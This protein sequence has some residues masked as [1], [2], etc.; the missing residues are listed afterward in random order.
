MTKRI[1]LVMNGKG[2]VG[3]SFFA[4]NFVQY[5]LDHQIESYSID[6]DNEN[7]TLK[8]FHPR[9]E[10]VN[11]EEPQEIDLIFS[12]LE[13][14]ELVTVDCRAASTDLFL[15]Y[16]SEIHVFDVLRELDTALTV[17]IPIN[18]EADSVEQVKLISEALE[19]NCRYIVVRNQVHS[20]QFR[21][22]DRSKT[23]QRLMEE[24]G[25]QELTMPKLY[26][27]LVTRLH[28]TGLTI[29]RALRSQEFTL[30]DRQRL[31]NWQT[32]F[33]E[34]LEKVR[35]HLVPSKKQPP[36]KA[37]STRTRKEPSE[38]EPVVPNL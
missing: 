1:V 31:K 21:I 20:D 18:H 12:A 16:F 4:T 27:W 6:T 24:L 38:P 22:F 33:Y 2:G 19:N 30:I 3:K 23:C 11:I 17:I 5:L 35:E 10:F 37:K 25:G 14:H 34:E 9:A 29:T 8:R 26:D 7:S 36:E 13:K 32:G 28:E 15:E